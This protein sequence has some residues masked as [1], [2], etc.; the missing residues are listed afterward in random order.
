MGLAVRSVAGIVYP[1]ATVTQT[2]LTTYRPLLPPQLT[3]AHCHLHCHCCL[4]LQQRQPR[5][6]LAMWPCARQLH[7][8]PVASATV[9]APPL[10]LP[11]VSPH[12]LRCSHYRCH[13]LQPRRPQAPVNQAPLLSPLPLLSLAPLVPAPVVPHPVAPETTMQRRGGGGQWLWGA[14]MAE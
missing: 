10:P 2:A 8:R 14:T 1:T 12:C 11:T 5:Q 6:H 7:L 13:W 3:K 9:V 4:W